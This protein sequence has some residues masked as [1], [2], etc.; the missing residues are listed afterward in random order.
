[1]IEN[2]QSIQNVINSPLF[3]GITMEELIPMLRCLEGSIKNFDKNETVSDENTN[4]NRFGLLA[5]GKLQVV[6]YDYMGN[7]TIIATIKPNQ[8]FGE[9]F[10]YIRK[11]STLNVEALT[12]SRVLFLN[13][14]K[15][16]NPCKNCCAFHKRLINN[17]LYIIANKNINLIEKIE[18]MSQRTTKE[19]LLAFLN[20]ESIKN[21]SR[22]FEIQYDRQTL[23]DYLGVERSAMSAEISKLRNEKIIECEKN[24]FK[25]L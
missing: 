22:K 17:L 23:A 2:I 16:S 13:S 14:E 10:S 20:L 6:Q 3:K 7:R 18:C 15:L 24:K 21:N 1:M 11:K 12:N 25:L 8:I 9:T 19:K 4:P 5:E